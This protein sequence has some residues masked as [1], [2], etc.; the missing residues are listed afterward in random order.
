MSSMNRSQCPMHQMSFPCTFRETSNPASTNVNELQPGDISLVAALGDSVIGSTGANAPNLFKSR[1]QYRGVS[2]AVGSAET[3]RTVTTIPNFLRVFNPKL[4]GGSINVGGEFDKGSNLNLASPGATSV[5]LIEQAKRLV[6]LL[7]NPY[8]MKKWKLV[9]IL[10]GHNDVCTHPCNTTYTAFDAS[11]VPYRKR[12]A[13]ALDMLRDHLPNTFVNFV[14]VLDLNFTFDMFDKPPFCY[15][16]HS[17]VC[18]CLFGG[19]GGTPLSRGAMERLLKGYM[20]EM[21]KLINSGRYERDDFTVVI[22]PAFTEIGLFTN[23]SPKTGKQVPDYSFFAPDC[24]HPSQKLHSLMARALWNNMLSPVGQKATSW[25][26]DPPFLC[27]STSSPYLA[28]RLNSA[29]ADVP[30]M[31]SDYAAYMEAVTSN[32]VT[33]YI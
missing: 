13:Q 9:T 27:P 21:Y 16:A 20:D 12:V 3:W 30:A 5:S 7:S 29:S 33:C 18:P 31:Q 28:T 32:R 8:D 24:L 23:K 15:L 6:K 22:Q 2:F 4:V 25:S 10:I 26:R 19:F 14:P 11:P 1:E 17:Y